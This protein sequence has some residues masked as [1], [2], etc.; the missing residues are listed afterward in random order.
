MLVSEEETELEE[1]FDPVKTAPKP[2]M[3]TPAR[4]TKKR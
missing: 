2:R 4:R 1:E 3:R